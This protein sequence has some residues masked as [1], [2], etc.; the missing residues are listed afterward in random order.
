MRYHNITKDDLLNGDGFRVVLWVS[1]CNHKCKGCHNPITWNPEHGLIFDDSAKQEIFEE[2]KK[3]YIS[4]LTLSG[5]DPLFPS[6]RETVTNLVKEVKIN[7]PE[8]NIWLYTGFKY[9]EIYDLEVMKYI[10]VLVDGKFEK[11][12]PKSNWVGSDNQ[13]VIRL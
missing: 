8:K 1:G 11:E 10:D 2:L 9:E 13:K 5:G 12:R 7:F 3:D 4:G 6:N